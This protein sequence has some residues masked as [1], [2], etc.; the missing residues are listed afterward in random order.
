MINSIG[1]VIKCLEP[2]IT[3]VEPVVNPCQSVITPKSNFLQSISFTK[4][5]ILLVTETRHFSV[6][7]R[8]TFGRRWK[9]ILSPFRLG[10][11]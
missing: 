6:P 11:A 2:V 1:A 3:S 4:K 7:R 10:I 8:G 5:D 9:R